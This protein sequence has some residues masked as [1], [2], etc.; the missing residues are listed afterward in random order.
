MS[1]KTFLHFEI[2]KKLPRYPITKTVATIYDELNQTVPKRNIQRYLNELSGSFSINNDSE[3]KGKGG[4]SYGWFWT[5]DA[6][7]TNI[8]GLAINQA[9]S[10]SLIKKY[11][12]PL[13]P[14]VTLQELNPFF[15]QAATALEGFNENPLLKWPKKIAVLEAAQPLIPP[16]IDTE[17]HKS[18][19]EALMENLQLDITY[20]PVG[21]KQQDYHLNPLGLI[22][23]DQVSYLVASKTD[24]GDLRKFALHRMLGAKKINTQAVHPKDFD[25]QKYIVENQIVSNLTSKR[26]FEP[27]ELK[28]IADKWVTT[29]L[30][31]SRLSEDQLIESIDD[32]NSKII[33]TVQETEQLFWWLLGFGARVEVLE[34]IKLREKMANSV[35]VLA[36]KYDVKR[37]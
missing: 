29:H 24:S 9:L 22:L 32:E 2:L 21:K 11:L 5:P 23:R 18:V 35:K 27:I 19:T 28:F 31:E 34:P 1:N 3:D 17:I 13:I 12:T 15:E 10:F 7:V 36:E 14:S 26:S 8:S 33:A 30:R 20:Q 4:Q 25:L 16:I 37:T 6:P